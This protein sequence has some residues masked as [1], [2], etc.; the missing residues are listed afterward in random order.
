MLFAILK[1]IEILQSKIE[2]DKQAVS[3]C[4]SSHVKVKIRR[5]K[6]VEV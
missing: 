3:G 4:D 2:K 1:R 5:N 6:L